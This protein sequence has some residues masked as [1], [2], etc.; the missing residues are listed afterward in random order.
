MKF[1]QILV[2]ASVFA[3]LPFSSIAQRGSGGWCANNNYNRLFNPAS[4]E[5]IK[6]SVV[7]VEKITPESGMSTGV[8]LMLKSEKSGNISVHLGP[9][10]YLD[11]QDVQFV[12]GDILVVKGSKI[13]YQNAPALIAMTVQKGEQVLTLRDKKGNPNWNGLQQGKGGGKNKGKNRGCCGG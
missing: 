5:E 10:W 3:L 12:A 1:I 7:S 11:N 8:H 9:S 4:M 13:T 2:W 6:G